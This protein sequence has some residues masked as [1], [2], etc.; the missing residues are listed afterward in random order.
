MHIQ[1]NNTTCTSI[2]VMEDNQSNQKK[3]TQECEVNKAGPEG[4]NGGRIKTSR[5][6]VVHR[7]LNSQ[8]RRDHNTH[9][10]FQTS[11]SSPYLRKLIHVFQK[12]SN[13]FTA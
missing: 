6:D 12:D 8:G 10:R 13:T 2:L 5:D 9:P 4:P 1:G 11:V 7:C 3:K